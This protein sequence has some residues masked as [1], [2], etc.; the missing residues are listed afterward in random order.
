MANFMLL[1]ADVGSTSIGK[2]KRGIRIRA[3]SFLS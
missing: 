1:F 3:A 2:D